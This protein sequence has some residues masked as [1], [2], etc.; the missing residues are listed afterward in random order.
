MAI[1]LSTSY[2]IIKLSARDIAQVVAEIDAN[3]H[4]NGQVY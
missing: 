1:H 4:N 3:K 2:R